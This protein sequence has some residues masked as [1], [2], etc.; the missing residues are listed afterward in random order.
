MAHFAPGFD[1][2]AL[3]QRQIEISQY[4]CAGSV[5]VLVWDILNHVRMEYT[6]FRK[7]KS[8]AGAI[9]YVMSRLGTLIYV[10][11]LTIFTSYAFDD[12][13]KALLA[14][15]SFFPVGICGTG[16][17]FLL[18]VC[19]VY[20]NHRA[21]SFVFGFLWLA[22]VGSATTIPLGQQGSV[23][24]PFRSC[25]ISRSDLYIGA[26][27][28]TLAI[29]VTA[30]FIAISTQF[31]SDLIAQTREAGG[32]NGNNTSRGGAMLLRSLFMDGQTYYLIVVFMTIFSAII[33]FIPSVPAV[34]R[35]LPLIP[36]A[37]LSSVMACRVYRNKL[38]GIRRLPEWTLTMNLSPEEHT[39]P[40]SAVQFQHRTDGTRTRE[41]VLLDSEE[42]RIVGSDDVK[43]R[44]EPEAEGVMGAKSKG[45]SQPHSDDM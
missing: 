5:A 28:V 42:T 39:I 15:N 34:Y 26:S 23:V 29:L 33:L 18:R 38:L 35:V 17:L 20:P 43:G 36:N 19:N 25:A 1:N 27:P 2:R 41:S 30:T 44:C 12:C 40:L 14:F 37:T 3:L 11:G 31:F 32:K 9:A 24:G 16:Y 22:A 10:L 45:G 8:V 7:H 21:I 4:V 6:V 13:D